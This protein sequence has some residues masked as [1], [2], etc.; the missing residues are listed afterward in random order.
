M[1]KKLLFTII[2]FKAAVASQGQMTLPEMLTT[3]EKS[4][5]GLKMYEAE[6]RAF[7]EEAK[8]AYSWMAPEAGAGLFMTPYK[9]SE[10]KADPSMMKEGMGFFMI[11]A[12]QMFPNRK[13]QNAEAAWMRSM[14]TVETEKRKIAWNELAYTVKKS[15]YE[16]VVLMKKQSV[17]EEGSLLLDF[18]IKSAEIRYKNGLGKISAYY[19]AKAALANIDNMK[20]ML[21]NEMQQKRIMLNSLMYRQVDTELTIDT[22][23]T[24]K[25][26]PVTIFDSAYLTSRRSDIQALQRSMEVNNLQRSAELAKL[27]PEFGVRYDHMIGLS[28]QPAQFTIMGMVK[29]PLAKWSSKMNKAKAESLIW[30]NESLKSQQQMILNEARGMAGS[31]RAE[32]ETKK[33]QMRLYETQIVPS[34]RKNFQTMQLGYEQNTE[35]LF[36]LFDAWEALN[37]TQLEYLDQLKAALLLQA[38]LEKVLEIK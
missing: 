6:A 23:Y 4:N 8:G 1:L 3:V 18:M 11:S 32:L 31:A 22:L 33:K 29:F 21:E 35:Q 2:A 26:F 19:K 9:T 27:K 36:E 7:N 10:I 5:P 37:M 34:L 30:Q 14:S 20:L 13:K 17:L 24:W 38:E 25:E 28:T 15:Y 12:Q 16:W